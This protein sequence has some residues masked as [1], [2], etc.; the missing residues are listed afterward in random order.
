LARHFDG[1]I[2][3]NLQKTIFVGFATIWL[4][5]SV[6]ILH[7]VYRI[8][9]VSSQLDKIANQHNI[10][11][12][13]AVKMRDILYRRQLLMR[14]ALM[15]GDVFEREENRQ[16]LSLLAQRFIQ[17]RDQLRAMPLNVDEQLLI[18]R[19]REELYRPDQKGRALVQ[20][21]VFEGLDKRTQR[22]LRE[23]SV[24]QNRIIGVLNE[25][26]SYE[27]DL[28]EQEV[29]KTREQQ[30]L[31]RNMLIILGGLVASLIFVVS[32]LVMRNSHRQTEQ[33]ESLARFASENPRPVMRIGF[34][35]E[36]LYANHASKPILKHWETEVGHMVPLKWRQL[37]KRMTLDPSLIEEEATIG[38]K[39]YSMVMT[40]VPQGGYVNLYA[41]DITEREE[42]RRE[43]ARLAS[44]DSLTGLI[45]R[46]EMELHLETLIA[47]AKANQ[48]EH[49]FLYF[50]LDQFK[51]VNDTCGH[52][53]GDEMLRQIAAVLKENVRESDKLGR[54][55]GD[56]FGLLLRSCSL[57]R[58]EKIAENLRE[59]VEKFRFVWKNKTFNVGASLGV[60]QISSHSGN[61]SSVLSAAD[62]ACYIAK[63]AGRNRVHVSYPGD[64]QVQVRRGQMEWV[65]RI[66]EAI[67]GNQFV[68]Y[69]Q[70]IFSLN[71]AAP[72]PAHGELLLRLFDEDGA[73]VPTETIVSVAERFDLMPSVDRWVVENAMAALSKYLQSDIKR[74]AWFSI[75]VSGQSV[76]DANF[77]SF[78][79]EQ[80]EKAGLPPQSICFELTET[81]AISNLTRAIEFINT[82]REK[83]CLVALDDFGSGLSSFSY[84]KNLNIDYLKIDGSFV[85]NMH[86]DRVSAAMVEAITNVAREMQIGVIAEWVEKHA[87]IKLL[88]KLNVEFA[89]GYAFSEPMP[90]QR[91][92]VSK[93]AN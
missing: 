6:V 66:R 21:M 75:N 35:G 31:S 3:T 50:D 37:V 30:T 58:A 62:T 10:K 12:A 92:D 46:R 14:N 67:D 25:L 32:Y 54:L 41:H 68:L 74:G 70:E 33:I 40:P 65:Q 20:A 93:V 45:N 19:L 80:I 15:L 56:E 24:G 7:A 69:F 17:A 16:Q 81:S 83:G 48:S 28:I 27:T 22:M 34:S 53:A 84:L 44:H 57:V 11:I 91:P 89:Q 52:V 64:E 88:Q 59:I 47:D 8:N 23:V 51:V 76:S 2:K 36:M 49:S 4:I 82:V 71:Q 18:E 1:M 72:G 90:I 79:I 43:F 85:R 86:E 39:I 9:N 5:I 29:S 77:T 60:V 78:V 73:Q 26:V 61:L 42:I 13:L 38:S 63:E 87:T 55:G